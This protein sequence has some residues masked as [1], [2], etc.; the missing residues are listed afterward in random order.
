LDNTGKRYVDAYPIV[1]GQAAT[2]KLG[3]D[4]HMPLMLTGKIEKL[5]ET[6]RPASNELMVSG[7]CEGRR[8]YNLHWTS[9]QAEINA[10]AL[11]KMVVEYVGLSHVRDGTELIEDS[12]TVYSLLDYEDTPVYD[13]VN[14]V[15]ETCVSPDGA[16]GYDWRVCPD[17]K[18][19]S[20][21]IGSKIYAKDLV[22]FEEEAALSSSI[23]K[24]FNRVKVRGQ[25]TKAMPADRDGMTEILEKFVE[26]SGE[27]LLF[28]PPPMYMY[29]AAY[30]SWANM[31]CL[32]HN[33]N[34]NFVAKGRYSV[35]LKRD[36]VGQTDPTTT[37][38]L[39]AHFY[40]ALN[41]DM[42]QGIE[43]LLKSYATTQDVM[44]YL[45]DITNR[46]ILQNFKLDTA[47][48]TVGGYPLY[49]WKVLN[50]KTGF[51]NRGA[52]RHL[53]TEESFDWKHIN[54]VVF[55]FTASNPLQLSYV[56]ADGLVFTDARFEA[57]A[58]DEIS[59]GQHGIIEL[60]PVLDEQ[61]ASDVACGLRA[62]ALLN[63]YKQEADSFSVKSSVFD[64]EDTPILAGDKVRV[65]LPN[66]NISDYYGVQ[67]AE[68]DVERTNLE[69]TLRLGKVRELFLD[70]F[71]KVKRNVSALTRAASTT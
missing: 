32:T 15:V 26:P 70:K 20:F 41:L 45:Q 68:L 25:R 7:R 13:I 11:L 38:N 59:Q 10:S 33:P 27:Y 16:I 49:P 29:W 8:L 14:Y 67:W 19:Q 63:Y 23:L 51:K 17:G 39:I 35:R 69:L 4:P 47:E 48:A 30:P 42:Y 12:P 56:W 6:E 24:I 37:I 28:Y 36:P 21:P 54:L 66:R 46:Q 44:V 60:E 1:K 34:S 40:N 64:Y 22:G 62:Q 61:L 50:L 3:R 31:D 57:T 5:D 55:V 2:I 65:N 9:R 43:V 18:F 53:C 71:Y 58:E 52:W